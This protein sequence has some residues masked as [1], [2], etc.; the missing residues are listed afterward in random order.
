MYADLCRVT[1]VIGITDAYY[2]QFKDN[3]TD[4]VTHEVIVS[5]NSYGNEE[6][7]SEMAAKYLN[8]IYCEPGEIYDWYNHGGTIE[9]LPVTNFRPGFHWESVN[10]DGKDLTLY[11]FNKKALVKLYEKLDQRTPR[12]FLLNVI[13]DQFKE[14][15]D[16]KHYGDGWKFPNNSAI[17]G[18]VSL[19][20]APH[21]TAIENLQTISKKDKG[22]LITLLEIWGNG[23][24]QVTVSEGKEYIG[25]LPSELFFDIGLSS[26]E[27][28]G[29]SSSTNTT[30][31]QHDQK[32]HNDKEGKIPHLTSEE[33][34][35]QR[36]YED[37]IKDIEE[38]YQNDSILRYSANFREQLSDFISNAIN[39][40]AE[41]V[42][43]YLAQAKMK[44]TNFIY[45]HKQ[46]QQTDPEKAV[47]VIERTSEGRDIL[48]A[49]CEY[50]IARGW[51]FTDSHYFQLKLI[52]WLE[53]KK[54]AIKRAAS[55]CESEIDNY[56]I[57]KWSMAVE[58]IR[59]GIMGRIS[60]VPKEQD[61]IKLIFAE[62]DN[63]N[64]C[65]NRK[66]QDWLSVVEYL[67]NK[68]RDY[69]WNKEILSQVPNTFMGTIG[70]GVGGAVKVYRGYEILSY[71][72]ELI[73]K[74]WNIQD[75]LPPQTDKTL[76]TLPIKLL[77]DLYSRVERIVAKE[78]ELIKEQM[79]KLDAFFGGS[80]TKDKI[81]DLANIIDKLFINFG[82]H[83]IGFSGELKAK[84][85][86]LIGD[87]DKVIVLYK[88][89]EKSLSCN[90]TVEL[91]C[92]YS[93]NPGYTLNNLADTLKEVEKIAREEGE[94]AV[95]EH[96]AIINT[97]NFDKQI[98]D[99]TIKKMTALYERIDGMEVE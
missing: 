38:W 78:K 22:R 52:T 28:I 96:K 9:T 84:C 26:F 51:E 81:I 85:E 34:R 14:Y 79:E 16:G 58:F 99:E 94:W 64:Y 21:S 91:L 40:Q 57:L 50:E 46:S 77:K 89:L 11:P 60:G 31:Q 20:S 39:W 70:K 37:R 72:K 43:A 8:A 76:L 49:L 48:R 90:N 62:F 12:N 82:T 6:F 44:D 97:A 27:G 80:I 18:V 69:E 32:P 68:D 5:E 75:E 1:A 13:R 65:S 63:T 30:K 88:A 15:A 2:G 53:S 55:G 17:K 4:R 45:I 59:L 42:P 61:A 35:Q 92:L 29:D 98:I 56:P 83:G 23:T 87:A 10:I 66:N 7:L 74:D 54:K 36:L 73:S 93:N 24:A 3:F 95:R 67:K 41:G 86:R 71:I 33:I 25:S 19:T 47:V